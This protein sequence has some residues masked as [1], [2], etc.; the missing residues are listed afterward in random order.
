MLVHQ[1]KD[2]ILVRS[3]E[4]FS[5]SPHKYFPD[6][7]IDLN[8]RLNLDFTYDTELLFDNLAELKPSGPLSFKYPLF[9]CAYRETLLNTVY[10]IKVIQSIPREYYPLLLLSALLIDGVDH[11]KNYMQG[12]DILAN[13]MEI[14]I[15][16]ED[17]TLEKKTVPEIVSR[18]LNLKSAP[19]VIFRIAR[20]IHLLHSI[21]I[22][23]DVTH[24]V[25]QIC[26]LMDLIE[27]YLLESQT[28]LKNERTSSESIYAAN[29][30]LLDTPNLERL[31]CDPQSPFC[32][33]VE[34]SD[35]V[36]QRITGISKKALRRSLI[37]NL[38]SMF[39][40]QEIQLGQFSPVDEDLNIW[41][42]TT[43]HNKLSKDSVNS[44]VEILSFH[45][46]TSWDEEKIRMRIKNLV[47]PTGSLASFYREY[48]LELYQERNSEIN[49]IVNKLLSL[50]QT[51]GPNYKVQIPL[52]WSELLKFMEEDN[53]FFIPLLSPRGL[54]TLYNR[55]QISLS[56]FLTD[57]LVESM[58]ATPEWRNLQKIDGIYNYRDGRKLFFM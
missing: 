5:G 36:I 42:H 53:A 15:Y 12:S 45:V 6:S 57:L 24:L 3:L 31:I 27:I 2:Y 30:L 41:Y 14:K 16:L 35:E 55:T 17:L 29:F 58:R 33:P 50:L 1:P 23:T 11:F 22:K 46:R 9:C 19:L 56:P 51:L 21:I 34:L 49:S 47:T 4:K 10:Q 7:V 28:P 54:L 40:A 25:D 39:E 48:D 43:E 26:P 20:A 44:L 8:A 32:R 37:Q 38:W 18:I 13:M 52:N